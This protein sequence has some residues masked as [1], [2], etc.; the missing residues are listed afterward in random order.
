M[1]VAKAGK[2]LLL[3]RLVDQNSLILGLVLGSLGPS[4]W[5][6][7][8][9][10]L[11][12]R[13][14]G[15]DAGHHHKVILVLEVKLISPVELH[16]DVANAVIGQG[17]VVAV[18]VAV[19]VQPGSFM[20]WPPGSLG[21]LLLPLLGRFILLAAGGIAITGSLLWLLKLGSWKNVSWL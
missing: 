12:L 17:G 11:M 4:S 1:N 7:L 9:V 15:P 19:A 6:L 20:F 21:R 3:W 2:L 14:L 16:P 8:L 10:L 13:H 5:S 18:E